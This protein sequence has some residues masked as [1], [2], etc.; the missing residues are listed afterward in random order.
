MGSG[1]A[2]AGEKGCAVCAGVFV[3]SWATVAAERKEGVG[4]PEP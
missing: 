1:C 3:A 4:V 2:D